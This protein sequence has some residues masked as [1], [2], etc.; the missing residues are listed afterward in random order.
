M[1]G[2]GDE[3][4]ETA[5]PDVIVEK[6]GAMARPRDGQDTQAA[7]GQ[8]GTVSAREATPEELADWDHHTV[9]P[10][11]GNALQ[12]R[13]WATYRSHFGWQPVFLAL[14]DGARVLGLR[15]SGRLIRPDRIYL[16]RGPIPTDAAATAR[17]LEA[18]AEWFATRGVG[19]L[20]SDAEVPAETGYAAL[21]GRAGFQPTEEIQP[22]RHRMAVDLSGVADSD[23]LLQSFN[24]T[25][26]N[27]V[28][29]ALRSDLQVVAHNAVDA[30]VLA[31]LQ[32]FHGLV[33]ATGRRKQFAV[34]S[35]ARFLDWSQQAMGAGIQVFIEARAPDGGIAAAATFYRHG[36]RWTYAL[37]ADDPQLRR[38]YAGAVR[39][40]VWEAMRRALEEGR[41]EMDLG[42]VDVAG[43]RRQPRPGEPEHG[44]LTFKE[45]FG[46]KWVEMA[47]AH[48]IRLPAAEAGLAGLIGRLR[49]T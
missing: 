16:S 47:G 28:R 14:S 19:V 42:G 27:M 33:E 43:A 22:S 29:A 3:P 4:S 17:R 44:M 46:A 5:E 15:R 37:A 40:V 49:G 1:Q 31:R 6:P 25:T 48:A 39:L 38:P 23:A 45:S 26:R 30:T 32:V 34:A 20:I 18:C 35:R 2:Q 21:I 12:S 7:G 41:A 24:A 10:P 11:A 8:P 13:G 9:D 36:N